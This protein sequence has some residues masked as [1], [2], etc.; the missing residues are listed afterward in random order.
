M[1]VSEVKRPFIYVLGPSMIADVGMM[2]AQCTSE[3]P[4]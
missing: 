1:F 3:L 4:K 2:C